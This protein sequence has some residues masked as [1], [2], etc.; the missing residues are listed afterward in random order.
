ML[1]SYHKHLKSTAYSQLAHTVPVCFVIAHIFNGQIITNEDTR[2][3]L[4]AMVFC[5]R[6]LAE[7][8]RLFREMCVVCEPW[9]LAPNIPI[10]PSARKNRDGGVFRGP[11][12]NPHGW[13]NTLIGS[14]EMA[15]ESINCFVLLFYLDIPISNSITCAEKLA[16]MIIIR[17]LLF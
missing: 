12:R 14:P 11:N 8:L 15:Q 5:L 16:L 4:V 2:L 1:P 17:K 10:L 13:Q 6:P 9:F 7:V 3:H